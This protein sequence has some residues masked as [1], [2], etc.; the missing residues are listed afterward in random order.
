MGLTNVPHIPVLYREIDHVREPIGSGVILNLCCFTLQVTITKHVYLLIIFSCQFVTL[1]DLT[2][3]DGTRHIK[4][5]KRVK[6]ERAL[7]IKFSEHRVPKPI[8]PFAFKREP[9]T[10][11]TFVTFWWAVYLVLTNQI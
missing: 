6:S 4:V 10:L 3:E 9:Q 7:G 2:A 1:I 11:S 5:R 8:P